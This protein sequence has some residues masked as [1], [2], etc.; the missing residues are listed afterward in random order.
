M[1]IIK[2]GEMWLAAKDVGAIFQYAS[3]NSIE[4]KIG[5]ECSA[6]DYKLCSESLRYEALPDYLT[7]S[8]LCTWLRIGTSKAY[9]LAKMPGFPHLDFGAKKIFPKTEV[10]EWLTREASRETVPE[11]ESRIGKE[12][13]SHV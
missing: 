10:K 6:D 12:L 1:T 3:S 5:S 9:K 4:N 8:E 2:D 7:I 11:A 13:N